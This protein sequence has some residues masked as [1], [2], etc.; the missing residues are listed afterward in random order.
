MRGNKPP[1]PIM[2]GTKVVELFLSFQDTMMKTTSL[3]FSSSPYKFGQKPLQ[4]NYTYVFFFF[5]FQVVETEKQK[6]SNEAWKKEEMEDDG[7]RETG[8]A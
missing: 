3:G 8:A 2:R 4:S 5:F 1:N 7:S 6:C